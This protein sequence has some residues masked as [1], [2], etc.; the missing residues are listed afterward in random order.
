MKSG[1]ALLL[2]AASVPLLAE[3][4]P[5]PGTDDPRLQTLVERPGEPARLVT[6]PDASLTLIMRSG[7][8]IQQVA[9]SDNSAF[10]VTI[11]GDNDSVSITPLRAGASAT[12][13][14]VTGTGTHRFNL[15]T[16]HGL[17]A[18]YVVRMVGATAL[19]TN[20]GPS[21]VKPDLARMS[22]HYAMKGD[23]GL[24][25]QQIA[26]DGAKTY[27]EWAPQQSLPAVLG[28]G[29]GG[30][31]VVPGYMRHGLFTI[32][33]VYSELVFRIDRRETIAVRQSEE[34]NRDHR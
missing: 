7:E 23:R 26:D 33:R 17:A 1:F 29:P 22:G 20:A 15:E 32:D 30:E 2:V 8:R 16:G 25:P 19:P 28:M 18:A 6:F 5:Q 34:G 14:V 27:I 21:V 12:M 31:E 9:L 4:V 10:H 13:A 3:T 11:T 24:R